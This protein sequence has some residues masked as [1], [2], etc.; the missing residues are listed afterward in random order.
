MLL[1]SFIN[2]KKH[3]YACRLT[4]DTY[5][6]ELAGWCEGEAPLAIDLGCGP[7]TAG[8]ALCDAFPGRNWNYVG[9]DTATAMRHKADQMLHAAQ[10]AELFGPKGTIRLCESWEECGPETFHSSASLLI[11]CSYLF[12]SASLNTAILRGLADWLRS[13]CHVAER[14]VALL[15][16]LNSTNPYAN[17]NYEYFKTLVGLDP[18]AHQPTRSEVRFQKNRSGRAVGSD[19]CLHELPI[20]EGG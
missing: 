12:A 7:G 1:Y 2:F 18:Q 19:E 8:L 3:F 15:V 14:P 6:S 4:Y 5:R 16:Y 10:A 20:L 9:V 17:M 13:V 11:I